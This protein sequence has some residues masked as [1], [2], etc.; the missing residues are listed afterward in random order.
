MLKRFYLFIFI[1]LFAIFSSLFIFSPAFANVFKIGLLSFFDLVNDKVVLQIKGNMCDNYLSSF[2]DMSQ[3]PSKSLRT[4]VAIKSC[5]DIELAKFQKLN[6]SKISTDSPLDY[7]LSTSSFSTSSTNFFNSVAIEIIN[8][9]YPKTVSSDPVISSQ[10]SGT[11]TNS[12]SDIG[13]TGNEGIYNSDI[14]K[15]TND[16][17]QKNGIIVLKE[18][19]LLDKIAKERLEDMFSQGYFKHVSP[20]GISVSDIAKTD[21]Y[22]YLLIGENIALGNFKNSEELVTAWMES[23]GHRE[24]ILNPLFSEIGV[25]AKEGSYNDANMLIGVQ[26]FGKPASSCAYPN[27][28]LKDKIESEIAQANELVAIGKDYIKDLETMESSSDTLSA[29]YSNKVSEYNVL[30]KKV[31]ALYADI[32]SITD[33]YNAQVKVYNSCISPNK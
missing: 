27:V 2:N 11:N 14:I 30:V 4:E 17:R 26:V 19:S 12:V 7:S 18:N 21:G 5:E 32:K 13:V 23:T 6:K 15:L 31:D 25:Y 9:I 16:E 24:N 33:I 29:A 10:S 3:W 22:E 28:S 8:K 20:Q 1:I